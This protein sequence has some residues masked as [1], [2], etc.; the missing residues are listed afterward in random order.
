MRYLVDE[1]GGD[2]ATELA[3]YR[4]V[5]RWAA[6][7]AGRYVLRIQRHV[8]D[9]PTLVRRLSELGEVRLAAT[10]NQSGI[11]QRFRSWLSKDS[12]ESLEIGGVPNENL[13]AVLTGHAAP[14]GAIAGD[15]SPVEDI[16]LFKHE[17]ELYVLYDYGRTQILD[18][19]PVELAELRQTLRDTGLDP[20]VIVAAPPPVTGDQ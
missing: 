9:D 4:A 8:Y 11:A 3:L 10:Q 1:R 6:A 14:P 7:Q 19:D 17:R 15:L 16:F 20:A 12:L 18:L 13:I 5:L 2:E